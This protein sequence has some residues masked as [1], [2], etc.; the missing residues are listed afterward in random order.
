VGNGV[1]WV[2]GVEW[3][4]RGVRR[5]SAVE[6]VEEECSCQGQLSGEAGVVG[7]VSVRRWSAVECIVEE[8]SCQGQLSGEAGV[9]GR[10]SVRR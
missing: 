8:C 6:C 9:V 1:Q 3:R 7:R 2:R 10:V 5:W 4:G